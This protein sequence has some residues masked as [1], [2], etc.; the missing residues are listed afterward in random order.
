LRL[1][2]PDVIACSSLQVG[3]TR[4]RRGD[5]FDGST[6]ERHRSSN[7]LKGTLRIFYADS[8]HIGVVLA[9]LR[10]ARAARRRGVDIVLG[11]MPLHR[12][13]QR[14]LKRAHDLMAHFECLPLQPSIDRESETDFDVAVALRRHPTIIAT[15]GPVSM[16]VNAS[17][18]NAALDRWYLRIE[19]LLG[20]GVDAWTAVYNNIRPWRL[21]PP[22]A[23]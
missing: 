7:G 10:S 16:G 3:E 14:Q 13:P 1:K 5:N 12:A 22:S 8:S 11:H 20:A 23:G 4:A 21:A 9:M 17:R 6:L 19:Q 18:G 15:G 2:A